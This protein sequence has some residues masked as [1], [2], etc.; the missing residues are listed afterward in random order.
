MLLELRI[1]NMALIDSLQLDFAGRGSGLA[2]FTGETGAGKSIILQ[3]IHLLAGGRGASSCIRGD[4]N[5]A[6][7]EAFFA[8]G[9]NQPEVLGLLREH[10]IEYNG[11]CIVRRV[12][13]RNG[14]S[15]FYV[16]DRL[17]TSRLAGALTEN[18]VNIASQHDHQ[19]LLVARR[20]LDFL[21]SF[22]ELWEQRLEFGRIY[23]R[24]QDLLSKLHE[25]RQQEQDKEQRRDF[26]GYQLREIREAE[27]S[28]GEDTELVHE[29]DRLK[30]SATLA[31]LAGR[32]HELIYTKVLEHLPL[33]RKNMEQV[34]ALD[35][36]ASELAERIGSACFEVEDL[37]LALREYRDAIPR[38]SSRLEDINERL[39]VLKQLQ[40]KYGQSL[41]EVA[42]FADR[43][44]QELASL[45]SVERELV[46][47][48]GEIEKLSTT[49]LAK[50]AELSRA[51]RRA[52]KKLSTAMRQELASLS[53]PQ[54]VFEVVVSDSPGKGMEALHPTGREL[55]EF[56][57]SANP[58]EPA[59]PL[60]KVASGGELSR[61][62]LAMKCLLARRDQVDTVIFDEVD[63]GIGGKAAEA[64]ARKIGELS[65]HHQVLCITHLPQIAARAAEH[66]M[67]AKNVHDGRTLTAITSL[68]AEERVMELARML[69][70]D[71]LTRQ[72]LAYA[73]ELLELNSNHSNQ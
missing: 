24:W 69:G 56:F 64:V 66:F 2:V 59:Q 35:G 61:L 1:E 72:T 8:V 37:E 34:A 46:L 67:V 52:A 27:I 14:R 49:A 25:L 30:S 68:D 17:V 7:V 43:A 40:R 50:A 70:G 39:G 65:G 36:S 23:G 45:D 3:A 29:R 44:E 73:R 60:V 41:E 32:S 16:N 42:A 33:I 47:V 12:F 28:P 53:F 63:A 5:R 38:D 6:V 13:T 51:R 19:Q 20:H 10:G 71:S 22:G 55:V 31:D 15:R 57:F 18:L 26:L 11:G 4:C 9:E 54:A 21:D 58:G 48:A 62:M